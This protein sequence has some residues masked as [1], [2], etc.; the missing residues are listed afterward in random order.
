[1]LKNKDN[2][3][4]IITENL[5]LHFF[6][7]EIY[8]GIYGEKIERMHIDHTD[9]LITIMVCGQ[10]TMLGSYSAYHETIKLFSEKGKIYR[11]L[12]DYGIIEVS[13][14]TLNSD[15][16]LAH[17]QEIY[18]HDKDK[19]PGYFNKK[20]VHK[21]DSIIPTII[22]P[23]VTDSIEA[24]FIEKNW[25]KIIGYAPSDMDAGIIKVNKETIL[26][27]IRNRENKAIT[28]SIFNI[29]NTDK[30]LASCVGRTLT[31]IY[32]D[33]YRKFINGDIVTGVSGL[34]EYDNLALH[35]PSHD[36]KVLKALLIHLGFPKVFA[37]NEFEAL[38]EHYYSQE[39]TEFALKLQEL[40]YLLYGFRI[41]KRIK[42]PIEAIRI[43]FLPVIH[44]KMCG[45]QVGNID[46]TAKNFFTQGIE[47]VEYAI[48]VINEY[49]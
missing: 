37:I 31:G 4:K 9:I 41:N 1:M 2:Y 17:K 45:L 18:Y 28:K 12:A 39:H 7:R 23:D 24:L 27:V 38:L 49:K 8:R 47:N 30:R 6:N 22:K 13:G 15:M 32:V 46:F 43:R 25:D 44:E 3:R 16:I 10:N 20:E 26:E 40:L 11:K 5:F 14:E 35:F 36:Y 33:D 42:L 21:L 34:N 19:Y 48:S 29:D